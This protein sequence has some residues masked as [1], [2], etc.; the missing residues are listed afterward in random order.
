[1]DH[2][3]KILMNKRKL[4]HWKDHKFSY[5]QVIDHSYLQDIPVWP[6]K[7]ILLLINDFKH[8]YLSAK[9]KMHVSIQ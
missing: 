9:Y 1:V 2:K 5:T 8:M 6:E 3:K 7:F 4:N